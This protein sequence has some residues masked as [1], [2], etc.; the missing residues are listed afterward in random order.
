MGA[1]QTGAAHTEHRGWS[2]LSPRS[3]L[4]LPK[5]H[6]WVTLAAP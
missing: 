3:E 5:D 4:A 6:W 2:E 1:P